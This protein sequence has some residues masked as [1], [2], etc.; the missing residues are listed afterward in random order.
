MTCLLHKD[1]TY[2]SNLDFQ[3]WDVGMPILDRFLGH[4]VADVLVGANCLPGIGWMDPSR[5]QCERLT[6]S[7]FQRYNQF[8]NMK[9]AV[10]ATL[11]ATASAFSLKADLPKVRTS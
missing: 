3:G 11:L 1:S 8:T 2:Y 7:L 4:L 5:Q 6:F 9:L 10:F